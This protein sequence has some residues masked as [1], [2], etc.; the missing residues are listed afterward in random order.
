[1]FHLHRDSGSV[2]ARSSLYC[3]ESIPNVGASR[4]HSPTTF[5]L[6]LSHAAFLVAPHDYLRAFALAVPLVGLLFPQ[7]FSWLLLSHLICPQLKHHF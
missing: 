7:L 5:P 4:A 3:G 2:V 6:A 1:M